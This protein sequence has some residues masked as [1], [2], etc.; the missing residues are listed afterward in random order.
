[1]CQ[2]KQRH[3]FFFYLLG[4]P[5]LLFETSFKKK[6]GLFRSL[7]EKKERKEETSV[8]ENESNEGA[9]LAAFILQKF[10]L[11]FNG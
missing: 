5:I 10:G 9:V 6:V 1:M 8:N 2:L 11:S 3:I 4:K 7:K